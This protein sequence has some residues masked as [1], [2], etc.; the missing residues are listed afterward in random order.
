MELIPI[1]ST[2]ILVATISTFILAIGAYILYKI[3]ESRPSDVVSRKK[4]QKAELVEPEEN[5]N[6]VQ[7]PEIESR[8]KVPGYK[9]NYTVKP[10]E[11]SIP[12]SEFRRNENSKGNGKGTSKVEVP[13]IKFI[14]YTQ[15]GPITPEEEKSDKVLKWR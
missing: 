4:N 13:A 6:I 8:E 3:R 1:L 10:V 14:K 12:V 2:I 11:Q 5:L 7:T 15:D 9:V